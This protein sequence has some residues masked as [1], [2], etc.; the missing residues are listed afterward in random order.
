VIRHGNKYILR[1]V[2]PDNRRSF[3]RGVL[4]PYETLRAAGERVALEQAGVRVQV[5]QSLYTQETIDEQNFTHEVVLYLGC[6]YVGGLLDEAKLP[7]VQWVSNTMLKSFRPGVLTD[8]AQ[9]AVRA[10]IGVD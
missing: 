1:P 3:P 4:K 9:D 5:T 6:T 8:A 2:L 10:I 7:G